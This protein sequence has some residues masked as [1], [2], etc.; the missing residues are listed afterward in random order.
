MSDQVI[1]WCGKCRHE[2]TVA[3][4]PMDASK[5]SKVV[6]MACCPKCAESKDIFIGPAPKE[7]T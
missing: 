5:L 3:Y 1:V 2:W 7:A 4:L 6:R